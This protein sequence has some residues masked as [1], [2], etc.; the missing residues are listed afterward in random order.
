MDYLHID[1]TYPL[2]LCWR[3]WHSLLLR[4]RDVRVSPLARW[5]GATQFGGHNTVSTGTLVGFSQIGRF[6]YI[7]KD[8]DLYSCRI[9]SFCSIAKAPLSLTAVFLTC[10]LMDI[11]TAFESSTV[12]SVSMTTYLGAG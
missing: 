6:T 11:S 9:G 5:N 8:C 4:R 10:P 3:V 12:S 7:R 1:F 2:K